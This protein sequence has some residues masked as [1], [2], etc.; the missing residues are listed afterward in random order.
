MK[1]LSSV[2]TRGKEDYE[3]RAR[4]PAVEGSASS[5]L[6]SRRLLSHRVLGERRDR[7]DHTRLEQGRNIGVS[8]LINIV[9]EYVVLE[10]AVKVMDWNGVC[11][12]HGLTANNGDDGLV[13]SHFSN[14]S[15]TPC[16]RH[17]PY[18]CH[19]TLVD[20]LQEW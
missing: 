2:K 4:G 16:S 3:G 7:V 10:Q 13:G 17:D 12:W 5:M 9:D 19:L 8:L 20:R 15:W 11:N 18:A 1:A 14:D 6:R